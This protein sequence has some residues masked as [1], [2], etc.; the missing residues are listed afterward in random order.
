MPKFFSTVTVVMSNDEL[1][2][3]YRQYK[4]R[5]LVMGD[6]VISYAAFLKAPYLN[7]F[8]DMKCLNC[9]AE[10]REHFG[11]YGLDMEDYSLPFPIDWCPE[12]GL[13]HLVP[14][15]IYHKLVINVFK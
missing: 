14:K 10:L 11:D 1:K 8:V 12:C 2:D 5:A 15:D 13:Q 9:H 7:V 4:D 3:A 6:Q